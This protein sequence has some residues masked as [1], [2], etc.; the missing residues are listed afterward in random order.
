MFVGQRFVYELVKDLNGSRCF[1]LAWVCIDLDILNQRESHFT[2]EF[3][4]SCIGLH[5]ADIFVNI[6]FVLR[7]IIGTL[8]KLVTLCPQSVL[9]GLIITEESGTYLVL[10]HALNQ[11]VRLSDVL[12]NIVKPFLGGGITLCLIAL[13]VSEELL[14]N[15][16]ARSLQCQSVSEYPQAQGF[17]EVVA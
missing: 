6:L 16:Q 12:F 11:T 1:V 15:N 10:I 17:Q 8:H 2:G 3:L 14:T 5:T 7:C 9:F 13:L 4:C